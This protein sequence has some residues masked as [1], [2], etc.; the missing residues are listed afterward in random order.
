MATLKVD[1]SKAYDRV[2]WRFLEA[3]LLKMDFDCKWVDILL[4]IVS[5]VKY[6][7]LHDQ[8]HIGPITP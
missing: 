3:V 5:S 2:K 4:E 1:M 8:K 6:H 7:I